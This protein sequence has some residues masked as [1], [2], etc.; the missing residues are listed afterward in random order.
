MAHERPPTDEQGFLEFTRRLARPTIYEAVS[1][2]RPISPIYGYRAT[3]NRWIHFERLARWPEGF[4]VMGDAVCCFN[5][6]Y[7]QGISVAA[8]EAVLLRRSLERCAGSLRGFARR[9]QRKLPDALETAWLMSTG[10]DARWPTTEGG[11]Q[12]A[13]TRL[14]RWYLDHF[15]RAMC[16]S[17]AMIETFIAVQH[18][19]LPPSAL[20]HPAMIAR[21]TARALRSPKL[22]RIRTPRRSARRTRYRRRLRPWSRRPPRLRRAR[23]RGPRA[24]RPGPRSRPTRRYWP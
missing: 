14:A 11:K 4:V 8:L 22:T 21:I 13:S 2:L 12:G 16:E 17:P 1:R 3:E 7:G 15:V 6:V 10:E 9:L 23:R 24:P 19:L 20:L 18:L 5:P